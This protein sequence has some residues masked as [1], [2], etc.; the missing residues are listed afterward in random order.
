MSEDDNREDGVNF[1]CSSLES[2]MD[3]VRK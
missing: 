2:M 1:I 3:E